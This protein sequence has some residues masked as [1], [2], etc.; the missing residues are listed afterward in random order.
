[1]AARREG[2]FL[3]YHLADDAVLDLVAALHR[4]AEGNVAE[5]GVCWKAISE[6]VTA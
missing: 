6:T 3:Y 2:K 1:V 5:S 4:I